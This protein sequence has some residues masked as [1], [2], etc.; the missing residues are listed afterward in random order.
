MLLVSVKQAFDIWHTFTFRLPL[1]PD[2]RATDWNHICWCDDLS[3]FCSSPVVMS[4]LLV[5]CPLKEK[6]F[7]SI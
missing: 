2:H 4:P 7:Q 3:N 6:I 5:P 1:I